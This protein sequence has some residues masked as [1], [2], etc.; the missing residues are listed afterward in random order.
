MFLHRL[1]AALIAFS[2]ITACSKEEVRPESA[3]LPVLKKVQPTPPAKKISKPAPRPLPPVAILVS[4]PIPAYQQVADELARLLPGR[5]TV[6]YINPGTGSRK[7]LTLLKSTEY[8]QFVAI[9]LSAAREAKALAGREDELIFCQVFNYQDYDLVGPRAKGVAA[10][11]GTRGMFATWSEMSPA[12]KSVGV[13]TGPGL[14][15][16]IAAASSEAAI[17]GIQLYHRVVKTDKE[18]LFEYKRMAHLIQGLWL[19]PD[20]RVLSGRII[21]EVMSFSVRNSKQVAVFSDDILRLGG[22]LSV[23][24]RAE[25]IA[26]KVAQRLQEANKG[27]GVPGPD[28]LLLEEG[29]I[30][31]NAIAARRYNLEPIAE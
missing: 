6:L 21:K 2:L 9:G 3:A 26:A 8:Q 16:V 30:Q 18:T 28:L 11:P 7:Q 20:N 23:T 14:E 27:K 13:I 17:H 12:L 19:L 4:E 25:E 5:S 24:T 29:N 15:S 31:V 1:I 22:L 10:L